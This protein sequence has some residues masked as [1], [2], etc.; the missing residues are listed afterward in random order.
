[1]ARSAAPRSATRP[2][3]P[4]AAR[5]PR[6]PPQ[7]R[8][9]ADL[10]AY[11]DSDG[12]VLR[13]YVSGAPVGA[14]ALVVDILDRLNEWST[15][16]GLSAALP[17]YPRTAVTSLVRALAASRLIERRTR[18]SE[19]IAD[20]GWRAWTPAAAF[21]HFATRDTPFATRDDA[22]AVLRE[23]ARVD[24]PPAPLKAPR[25]TR[26]ATVSLPS[27]QADGA[28]P[29]MLRA[30]RTW[31]QFGRGPVALADVATLLGLTWGVQHWVE[32]PP[33]GRMALKTSPSGGA[34]HS[35]EVYLLARTV[36][37]LARGI[38]HYD[39]DAHAL[40]TVRRGLTDADIESYLP[41][42][43]FYRDASAYF[44]MT[45]VFARVQWR[46]AFSRA[47]RTV[48][49]EVGHHCQ[50]LLLTA[51]GLGLAPFCT[52]ALADS[53]LERALG[54]DGRTEAVLYFAG[55][56]QRP[57]KAAWAPRPAGERTPKRQ[58][59]AWARRAAAS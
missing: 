31:R 2:A 59:P 50:N 27:A 55:V 13:N 26:A 12:L 54:V 51:T 47:Y 19:S 18:A 52:M 9:S 17:A 28:W 42:Q 4:S 7:Y 37:G 48:L 6:Q 49:A 56:G 38:Y 58:R 53:T 14:T 35:I 33:F 44:V 10:V 43:A 46:Y 40:R 20:P 8:R 11:W 57:D 45:S 34:R 22:K 36:D 39:P 25:A 29:E 21:F 3:P 16:E 32:I 30:R 1:M 24:P 5:S 41:H 23:K 15:V